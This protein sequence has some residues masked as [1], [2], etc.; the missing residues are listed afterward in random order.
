MKASFLFPALLAATQ[1]VS[2]SRGAEPEKTTAE[3]DAEIIRRYDT[4][5]DGKLDEAEVAAVKEEMLMSK[6]EKRDEKRERVKERQG[7]WLKEFDKNGDG[8]LDE[9]E[10]KTMETTVRARM[11]KNPQMLKRIDTN[12]DGKIDDQEWLAAREKLMGR[13]REGRE[14]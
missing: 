12:S 5:K 11:E 13:L 3:R 4:N 14:K 9:S 10:K 2:P 8:K 6:M 7:E 1:F